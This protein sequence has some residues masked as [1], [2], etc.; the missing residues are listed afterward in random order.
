MEVANHYWF[1]FLVTSML[2]RLFFS[3]L[4]RRKFLSQ[5]NPGFSLKMIN[6]CKNINCP[7]SPDLL[8]FQLGETSASENKFINKHLS[9]C[10]FCAAEIEIYA[11]F[12]QATEDCAETQIPRPLYELAE[13][14]LNNRQKNFS[15]LNKILGEN[16]SLTLE[17]A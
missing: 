13:A 6:F 15:L 17:K 9:D 1:I 16:E 11:H 7:T 3:I 8:A 12:A 2:Q 4:M 14:L 10:E 5:S